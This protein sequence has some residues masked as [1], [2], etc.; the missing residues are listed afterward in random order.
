M[1][2]SPSK[3]MAVSRPSASQPRRAL[4]PRRVALGGRRHRLRGACRPSAPGGRSASAAR[5]SSGCTER[6]SLAPKPP[7][8]AE[9]RMRTRSRRQAEDARRCRRGPCRAPGCRRGSRRVSPSQ[10]GGAGL[11]LDIGVLD[12][13]GA[14]LAL[15]DVRGGRRAP[16]STSPRRDAALDQQVAGPVGVDE[17]RAGAS[18]GGGVGERRAAAPRRPGSREV[19]R[20]RR[21][22]R[23]RRAPPPRR[24]SAPRPRR[25]P[26]GRRRAG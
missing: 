20:R 9:G 3:S 14:E 2:K 23:R 6:S 17:R 26:A 22:A 19:E 7:P 11:G 15:G 18:R 12:E 4:D 5:P 8:T 10:P 25:A 16:A 24:G 1:L 21:V 13:A